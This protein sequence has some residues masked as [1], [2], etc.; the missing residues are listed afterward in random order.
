MTTAW[1]TST[2][3]HDFKLLQA[4]CCWRSVTVQTTPMLPMHASTSVVFTSGHRHCTLAV[5]FTYWVQY[6]STFQLKYLYALILTLQYM[7]A[8]NRQTHASWNAVT[9]VWGLLRLTP[10]KFRANLVRPW[11]EQLPQPWFWLFLTQT[12]LCFH[13]TLVAVGNGCEEG[14]TLDTDGQNCTGKNNN[15]CVISGAPI[16]IDTSVL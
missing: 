3:V 15:T 1:S 13:F 10:I 11:L 16:S 6:Y 5:V 14:Y 4:A 8:T 2:T 12:S 7:A 9:L